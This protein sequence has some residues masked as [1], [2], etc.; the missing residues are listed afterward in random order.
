MRIL[1]TGAA[2][3]IGA[4][5]AKRLAAGGHELALLGLEPELLEPAVRSQGAKEMPEI[6]RLYEAEVAERGARAASEPVGA[7]GEAAV[8]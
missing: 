4:E 7:G 1:I 5:A 8:R 3:G 2:R 6:E